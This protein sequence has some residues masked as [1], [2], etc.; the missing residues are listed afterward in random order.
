MTLISITLELKQVYT[1]IYIFKKLKKMVEMNFSIVIWIYQSINF[2]NERLLLKGL[3]RITD[4]T[5]TGMAAEQRIKHTGNRQ[6]TNV[7]HLI[8]SII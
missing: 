5:R 3:P 7:K 1:C 6:A 4:K 8:P 2:K